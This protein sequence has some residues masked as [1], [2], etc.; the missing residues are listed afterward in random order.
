MHCIMTVLQE[1]VA[2]SAN[3]RKLMMNINS[4]F[5]LFD[6]VNYNIREKTL[7]SNQSTAIIERTVI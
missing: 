7:G 1:Q 4:A 6:I 3:V 2:I 5:A